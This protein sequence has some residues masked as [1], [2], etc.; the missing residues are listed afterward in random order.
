MSITPQSNGINV[1][2]S[3]IIVDNDCTGEAVYGIAQA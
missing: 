1:P 3:M 2:G